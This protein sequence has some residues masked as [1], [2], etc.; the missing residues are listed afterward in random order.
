MIDKLRDIVF[1]T[2][3]KS[4]RYFDLFIQALILLSLV[5]FSLETLPDLEEGTKELLHTFEIISVCIFSIEYLLR[6]F[7]T[8]KSFKYIFSFFGI[9]DLLA[10]L[11]F[12][13]ASGIDLRSVRVFRLFRLF[14]V[15]KLLQY[16][17]AIDR[18]SDAFASVKKELVVFGV[19]TIFLL[20]VAAVGIY[21]CENPAQPEL[22]KSVFHSLWWAVTTLTTVGYGDMYPITVGGKIF[23]TF[24]VFIGMGMVAIP[25]GLLASAFSNTFSDKSKN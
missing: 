11:P 15:F 2:N 23:T 1:E 7:L 4:G 18:V 3:S 13:L 20:Y 16:N 17:D 24:V 14:R 8:N 21:Y 6:V 5:S 10:I 9:I 25:T 12:Y 22:F 19:G